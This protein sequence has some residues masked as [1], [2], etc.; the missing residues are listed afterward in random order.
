MEYKDSGISWIGRVPTNWIIK[1]IKHKFSVKARV[2]WK[3]LKSDE[4]LS[5]GFAYLVTGSDF[6]EGKVTWSKCYH[7]NQDRYEDDPFI[8]LE[9][10][11][12]LITKDGTIGKLAVVSGKDKPACLNSGIFVVRSL[13]KNLD[14]KFLYWI[15]RSSIFT[16]FNESTAYGSTIQHLYQNVFL[17]FSFPLPDQQE[18]SKIII[19]LEHK[20]AQIKNLIDDKKKLLHLYAEE[21]AALIKAFVSKGLDEKVSLKP[22]GSEWLGEIPTHWNIVSLKWISKIYSG[23]TPSRNEPDYWLN[24]NIPWLNSGTVNQFMIT[25]A[26]EYITEKGFQSSSAKWIPINSLVI[27][28]AGQGKT[29]GMVA[30]V[31]MECTCNQ[32]LGVIVPSAEMDP[33]YLLYYLN[34]N[35]QNIRNLG[36]GDLR[37][38]INLEMVG[39]IKVPVLSIEEQKKIINK[40]AQESTLINLKLEKIK[41]LIAFLEEYQTALISEVVLGKKR[42]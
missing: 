22:S 25:T 27:A 16:H 26:S 23:G 42:I 31:M 34:S 12:L 11:D 15:L 20:V 41:K 28:L 13:E 33:K 37:D 1:K 24:G 6:D 36:G 35:Y 8:Q 17:E 40:I 32:S 39:S 5:E 18:Q 10:A 38:G 9:E 29:K 3:G 14:T 21:K 7:I 4:F 2:G 30:Q 19:Y